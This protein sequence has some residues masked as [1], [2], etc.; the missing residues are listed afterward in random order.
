VPSSRIVAHKGTLPTV[1]ADAFVAPN[2]SL[3][4][5]VDL[6]A[7]AGVWYGAVVRGDGNGG[8]AGVTIGANASIQERAVVTSEGGATSIGDNVVVG[9]GAQVAGGCTLHANSLVGVGAVVGAG[10]VVEAGSVVAAGS[11]VGEKLTVPA[12]QLWSGNPCAYLRDLTAHESSTLLQS[13]HELAVLGAHH[14]VE[15]DKTIEQ[16]E[17]E[18]ADWK[19]S[20]I[21]GGD[22]IMNPNPNF[23]EERPG[24]IFRQMEPSANV[25]YQ[26]VDQK[27]ID[28]R[29]FNRTREFEPEIT[30]EMREGG[31][32]K[33][34]GRS[35]DKPVEEV[36]Q[37]LKSG[38]PI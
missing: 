25:T 17:A 38:R 22:T 23:F 28:A 13:S 20:L 1:A 30:R 27:T 24:A 29:T 14:A 2:A 3:V 21:R 36:H 15:V 12:G 26:S 6:G 18:K 7:G 35:V 32:A 8:K 37:Q 33:N 11:V 9:V 34:A 5:K 16:I 19:E 4:G 10:A 31:K